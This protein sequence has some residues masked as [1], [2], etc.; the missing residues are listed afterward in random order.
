MEFQVG[1]R[2]WWLNSETDSQGHSID[3]AA[4][5]TRITIHAAYTGYA[6]TAD[7]GHWSAYV[8]AS[9]LEKR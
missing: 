3:E 5:I 1:D 8:G 9:E 2:V 7:N 6:I 4:V